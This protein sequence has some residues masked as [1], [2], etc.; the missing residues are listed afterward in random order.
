MDPYRE[1][2]GLN[3]FDFPLLGV[4]ELNAGYILFDTTTA[5]VSGDVNLAGQVGLTSRGTE[6]AV[7]NFASVY[8]V[9]PRAWAHVDL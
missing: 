5:T 9:R 6:T 1:T 4:L 8:L 3:T 7:F 2:V